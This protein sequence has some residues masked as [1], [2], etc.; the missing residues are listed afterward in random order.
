MLTQIKQGF[1]AWPEKPMSK[2]Q[3]I[4][5]WSDADEASGEVLEFPGCAADGKTYQ[6]A[7]GNVETIIQE[8]DYDSQET[9]SSDTCTPWPP[10]F[11]LVYRSSTSN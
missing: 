8:W 5:Y 2:Y 10:G 1:T 3:I 6:Q 9:Q 4:I 11:R 7:L